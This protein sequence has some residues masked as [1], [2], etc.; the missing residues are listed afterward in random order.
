MNRRLRSTSARSSA[1]SN[2]PIS[3]TRSA[4]APS[5]WRAAAPIRA[6]ASRSEGPEL[7]TIRRCGELAAKPDTSVANAGSG[8]LLNG[9]PAL[10]CTTTSSSAGA[11]PAASSRRS[12]CRA[13]STSIRI[14][15]PSRSGEGASVGH[16]SIA[17]SRSHWL[18][19]ECRRRNARGLGTARVYIH[20]R[21]GISYPIRVGARESHASQALRGPPCR[22]MTM[23]YRSRRSR[24]ARRR[25][26]ASRLRPALRGATMTLSRWGFS[27][28]TGSACG[29]TRYVR[30]ASGNVR[31]NARISGVVNTTSPIKRR[32]INKMF[33]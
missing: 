12:T 28:T 8:H 32:R 24:P 23:S 13:A 25:S 9:F 5:D 17:S 15:T 14:S 10:T 4:A 16:P 18:T 31:F 1:R 7:S 6:A 21:P 29:S 30:C 26:S 2:S 3:R 20:V 33:T 19:T 22:S 11:T 27:R